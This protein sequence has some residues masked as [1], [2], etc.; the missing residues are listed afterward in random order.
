M[1]DELKQAA[2]ILRR[3]LPNLANLV[4][5]REGAMLC[6]LHPDTVRKWIRMRKIRAFG[7]RG[8]YRVTL[9]DLLPQVGTDE[10]ERP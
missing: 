10:S 1:N 2:R 5:V 6:G 7:R 9:D 3:Q 4:S 8:C